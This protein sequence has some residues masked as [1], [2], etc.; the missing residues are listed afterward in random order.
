MDAASREWRALA[1]AAE[2][3]AELEAYGAGASLADCPQLSA[4][5]S[6]GDEAMALV[7]SLFE[8]L[9][10][11]VRDNPIGH[12]PFRHGFDGVASTLLLARSGRAQLLLQ[13]REPGE[14]SYDCATFSDAERSDM[15]LA[16]SGRA[17]RIRIDGPVGERVTLAS[18]MLPMHGGVHLAQYL[19]R[20]CL[21]IESVETRLVTL[22]LMRGAE[23]PE[24]GREYSLPE[25]ELLHMSA[26]DLVTSHR[27]SMVALLGRMGRTDAAPVLAEMACA[28]GDGSLRWQAIRECLALDS[29]T[30]FAALCRVAQ[31]S[32]DPLAHEAGALRAQLIETYPQLAQ[33]ENATCPA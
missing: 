3:M 33:L 22:R 6:C 2:A 31:F 12:P 26:G 10:D 32:G 28:Q 20:E 1:G 23:Q 17:R 19:S 21:L 18:D 29:A 13:A 24:L 25:G 15:V 30:G 7:S 14:N 4:M 27:A 5:F 9:C 11:A 16:G 8:R